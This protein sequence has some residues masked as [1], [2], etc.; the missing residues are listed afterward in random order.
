MPDPETIASGL[1]KYFTPHILINGEPKMSYHGFKKN[2]KVSIRQYTESKGHWVGTQIIFSG[3]DAAHC[4]NLIKTKKI[5]WE[6]LMMGRYTLSLGR[7]DLYFSRTNNFSD[8][9]KSFDAFLVNSRTKIQNYTTTRHIKLQNFPNGKVL[10]VNRRNNSLHYQVYQKHL[11]IR[12]E[13][14]FKHRQTKLVQNYLF[15]N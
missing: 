9:V 1:S 4:Y 12:F 11:S 7:I 2:Y 6:T 14:E 10:K 5:G 8:T 13:L 15:T 3:K